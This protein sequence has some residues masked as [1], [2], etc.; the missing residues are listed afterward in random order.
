[1]QE[2]YYDFCKNKLGCNIKKYRC[3]NIGDVTNL[4]KSRTLTIEQKKI[5]SKEADIIFKRIKNNVNNL[6][7]S[8]QII[9]WITLPGLEM[10]D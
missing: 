1:M 5:R 7:R 4:R 3:W 6:L 2:D 9:F 10:F 8:L